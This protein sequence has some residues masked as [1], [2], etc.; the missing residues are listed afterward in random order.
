MVLICND[1]YTST[2]YENEFEKYPFPLSDFQKFAI[3]SIIEGHHCLVT[4]HTGSGKTLPG[5]FAIKH[6]RGKGKKVVYT[7]PIKALSNQKYFEFSNKYPDISFGIFTGD[8]KVNPC[9]D[10]LIMTT[11]I[12]M[13]YLFSLD[14]NNENENVNY[15][16]ELNINEDL[17]CVIFDEVHYINDEHRG[18]NWE[19]TIL[20]LPSHIQM[21]MLSATI[22]APEK[23][24]HWCET[25]KPSDKKVYLS[26]THH[27]VVPLTH[28][29]YLTTNEGVF[30]KIKDK[31]TQQKIKSNTNKFIMLKSS[32]ESFN[33]VGHVQLKSTIDLFEKNNAFM[34]KTHVLN[35]VVKQLNEEDMLPA[36]VFVFSRKNVETYAKSI[37]TNIL[38][39]DSK[40][41]YTIRNECDQVLRK[42]PNYKEYMNLPEYD[43]LTKLLEKG[44]GIHHSGMIPILREIVETMI[45]RKHIKLLFATE[46]FAIGLDCPIRTAVFTSL[47]KFDGS[48]MRYLY[49]HEY[50][51]AAGRA[52]RRGLD[53]VGHVV[54]CNNMFELPCLTEYKEILCGKPQ[55]LVSKFRVSYS[56]ILS[57]MKNNKIHKSD[58]IDF[59]EKSMLKGELDKMIQD[60][61]ISNNKYIHR[62]D[63]LEKIIDTMRTPLEICNRYLEIENM[64]KAKEQ[65]FTKISNKQRKEAQREFQNI[66][67]NYKFI[68][69]DTDIIKQL[70][71][72]KIDYKQSTNYI[73]S[74]K[75]YIDNQINTVCRLLIENGYIEENNEISDTYNLT[76]YGSG[77]SNITEIHALIAMESMNINDY[78][79]DFSTVELIGF[80]SIFMG[81]K[82]NDEYRSSFPNTNNSKIK[83][84]VK[85][86]IEL[87]E[88]Y[89]NLQLKYDVKIGEDVNELLTFDLIDS[90]QEWCELD[91]E[92]QCKYFIQ[93]NLNSIEVSI[94]E[95]NKG[96]LK[97]STI[98]REL[99]KVCEKMEKVDLLYKLSKVDEYILKF[100]ATNQSIYV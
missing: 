77:A 44:I 18:Q 72:L 81:I 100:V 71:E 28:Y 32:N 52:G 16:F 70:D 99:T 40:V 23:F 78:Y 85:S 38:E 55:S 45:S 82:L 48:G 47:T 10:V 1:K 4:A 5:E 30:K 21:V 88:K 60:E 65:I 76:F 96:I 59:V 43:E 61:Q 37:T 66:K 25:C 92:H 49:P 69:Q 62:I 97:I 19:Q 73:D 46:S 29:G 68:K 50:G 22:D 42:L 36:I 75:Y 90:L 87:Y 11:E 51:Q 6:F 41:P 39:F 98:A 57:L 27:R 9:A 26:T 56:T 89:I 17:G 53:T 84:L 2:K 7:S 13:N 8:I 54:H 24:A 34:N 91:N 64:D 63:E 95:F 79:N 35:Q 80:L 31:E 83:A 14:K 15:D 3:E 94:G 12:L 58:F 33:D 86:N 93:T 20:M 67:D 74:C